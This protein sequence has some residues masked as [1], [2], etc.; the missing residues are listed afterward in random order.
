MVLKNREKILIIFAVIAVAIWIF[1]R[2]YFTPQSRKI[3]A[4]KAELKAADLKLDES[5]LMTK[6]VEALEAEVSRQEEA[7]KRLSERVLRGEEF[8]T[9]L[10]HLARESDSPQMKVVS[11]APQ[12][13]NLPTPE[14]KKMGSPPQYR[15]VT[16]QMVLH[17]TYS[18]LRAYLKGIEELPFLVS[19]DN[20]Q[21]EKGGGIQS[22]LKVSMGLSMYI[23]GESEVVKG[24]RGP[25]V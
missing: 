8:R 6:G 15:R 19:V 18:K 13:E 17:S 20:I 22:L 10:R 2:F 1:D 12:E 25:G 7:L 11:L 24:S 21:I 9:F 16:I 14:G 3:R 23:A 4:L 5:L